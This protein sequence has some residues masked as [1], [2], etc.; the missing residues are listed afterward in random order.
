MCINKCR[1]M[2]VYIIFTC[3]PLIGYAYWKTRISEHEFSTTCSRLIC[4]VNERRQHADKTRQQNV[5]SQ[6]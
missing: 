4:N 6:N 3:Q 1:E 2:R 5:F